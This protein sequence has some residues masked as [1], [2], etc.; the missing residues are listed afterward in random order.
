[1]QKENNNNRKYKCKDK[2]NLMAS[3]VILRAQPTD[4]TRQ[5]RYMWVAQGQ[6][7][8][9]PNTADNM[10]SS[11]HSFTRSLKT[12]QLPTIKLKSVNSSP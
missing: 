7:L 6:S 12:Y 4:L 3:A 2:S 11:H 9:A 5:R 1:V 10:S 8:S